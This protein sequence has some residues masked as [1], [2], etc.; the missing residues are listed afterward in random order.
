[1]KR[2]TG[3]GAWKSW[4]DQMGEKSAV[5]ALKKVVFVGDDLDNAIANSGAV[6]GDEWAMREAEQEAA[7]EPTHPPQSTADKVAAQLARDSQDRDAEEPPSPHEEEEFDAPLPGKEEP[8]ELWPDDDPWGRLS[9]SVR[10]RPGGGVSISMTHAWDPNTWDLESSTLSGSFAKSLTVRIGSFLALKD[11]QPPAEE[12]RRRRAKPE[13][14]PRGATGLP[15][16][17]TGGGPGTGFG[18]EA[19]GGE[20]GALSLQTNFSMN[21]TQSGQLTP[22][23]RLSSSFQLSQNWSL[24]WS[25]DLELENG[26]FGTQ[27]MSVVRDLHCWEF[28][29]TRLIYQDEPQYYFVIYLREHPEVKQEFGNRAVG[30]QGGLY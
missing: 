30:G 25:G 10:I 7:D 14:R 8:G 19:P 5:I 6:F 28:R 4:L 27:R 3:T 12:P 15:G 1:M 22:N 23:L 16:G 24:A 9:S 26:S 29:F 18:A 13:G 21:R 11:D 17:Y 2:S 20:P